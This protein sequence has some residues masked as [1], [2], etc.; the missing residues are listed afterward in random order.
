M[1]VARRAGRH[2]T[3]ARLPATSSRSATPATAT[4]HPPSAAFHSDDIEYVFGTLDSRPDALWRPEDRK[5]SNEIQNVL[6]QLRPH[7]RPQRPR[8]PQWP[9]YGPTAWQVMHLD[10]TTEARPDTHRDRYLFLDKAWSGPKTTPAA[11]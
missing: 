9:K 7:R 1:E 2:R 11:Q 8:P 4:T 5:L 6:D 3:V 10:A